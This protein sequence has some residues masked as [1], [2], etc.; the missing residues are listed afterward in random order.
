MKQNL[1]TAE[2]LKYIYDNVEKEIAKT[3]NEVPEELKQ[4]R[5]QHEKI[6]SEL[7]NLLN[8]IK[9][10]N[11]SK[12]VSDA[13]TDAESR[14]D[15]LKYDMQAL[16]FQRSNAFK[17]PAK[18][19]VEFRLEN[20]FETLN[21]NTKALALALKYLFGTIELEAIPGEC[22]IECG[23]LI[24]NRAHYM[25]HSTIDSLALL[26]QEYKGTNWLLFR[27]R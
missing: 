2:N 10:G 21:K 6:Q 27:K 23:N 16:E 14:S 4:K 17:A 9:I 1:L 24:Q 15:R 22:V 12:V 7:Q 11:F 25:A 18:E 8:F 3:L 20:L 26:D 13:L 19:W 5:A